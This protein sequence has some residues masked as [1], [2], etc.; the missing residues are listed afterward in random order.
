[1]SFAS[2][3]HVCNCNTNTYNYNITIIICNKN[4]NIFGR[5]SRCTPSGEEAPSEL[6]SAC[7]VLLS[8]W[9]ESQR[10]LWEHREILSRA[11]RKPATGARASE[12]TRSPRRSAEVG[13]EARAR[14]GRKNKSERETTERPTRRSR[15]V[16]PSAGRPIGSQREREKNKRM[17]RPVNVSK[18]GRGSV[19]VRCTRDGDG[20]TARSA[21]R[22]ITNECVNCLLL[23]TLVGMRSRAAGV[24]LAHSIL[25]ALFV[26]V[27]VSEHICV[28]V[29][30]CRLHAVVPIRSGAN[31]TIDP[32]DS[33]RL[34]SD[35]PD[36]RPEEICLGTA[37]VFARTPRRWTNAVGMSISV[38][39]SRNS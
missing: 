10:P 13:G 11:G 16:K 28:C 2:S 26:S 12:T 27:C 22:R 39:K 18:Y 9:P 6:R 19:L 29:C 15:T 24:D 4:I 32:S 33:I 7:F 23:A 8:L 20:A 1:M 21:R 30:V 25:L 14:R 35:S 17:H 37:K 34:S 38:F 5:D 36:R 31:R 3:D